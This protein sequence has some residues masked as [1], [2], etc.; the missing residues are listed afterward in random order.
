MVDARYQTKGTSKSPSIRKD[1]CKCRTSQHGRGKSA[2]QEIGYNW[3]AGC[4]LYFA[5]AQRHAGKEYQR[6]VLAE[7]IS[8]GLRF[9]LRM[10][11]P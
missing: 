2:A 8:K 11:D 1:S 10:T 9:E 4:G 5:G 6:T 7:A 3:F